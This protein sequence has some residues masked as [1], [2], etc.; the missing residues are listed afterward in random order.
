MAM[1]ARYGFTPEESSQ[2]QA[3]G[4]G[5]AAHRGPM[6]AREWKRAGFEPEEAA[7]WLD[8]NRM[9]HPRQ[10]TAMAHFGVTPATYQDGDERFALAEYDRTMTR[11]MDP[12]GVWERRADW[13]A[14][15]F[16]G[17]K[18]SWFADYGVGPTEAT[19]W[20]AVDLVHTFQEWRQ[21]RFGPTE[22]GSWA[23]LVGMRGSIT[24][25][26]LRDLGWTPEVAAEHMAG[27]DDHGRQAFLERPFHVRDRDSSRV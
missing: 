7:A 24:A 22:S 18:A 16:D 5:Y 3:A 9:I 21:Q 2:W 4:M 6:S 8:A 17:D 12:G 1:W 11:E 10:A 27:L 13:R 19:K 15:G 26:D 14:A 23:K 20:R 25:R